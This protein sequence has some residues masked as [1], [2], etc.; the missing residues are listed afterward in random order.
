MWVGLRRA[1]RAAR[2]KTLRRRE[3]GS[4]RARWGMRRKRGDE[5]R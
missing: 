1:P 3:R 4:E 2:E 5:E